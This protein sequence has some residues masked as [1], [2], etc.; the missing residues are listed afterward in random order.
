[1]RSKML[2]TQE[3]FT[4]ARP[5]LSWPLWQLWSSAFEKLSTHF[6]D[7]AGWGSVFFYFYVLSLTLLSFKVKVKEKT[8]T[9][10]A[11]G[12]QRLRLSWPNAGP[13]LSWPNAGPLGA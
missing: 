4:W 13:R 6:G 9:A 10:L 12:P 8:A 11:S 7:I 3:T 1:M 2:S 5:R